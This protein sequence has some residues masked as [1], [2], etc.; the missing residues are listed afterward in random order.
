MTI[1][2]RIKQRRKELGLSQ[3]QLA[4][5]MGYKTPSAIC[6]A[7]TVEDNFTTDRIREFAAALETTE[8]YLMGWPEPRVDFSLNDGEKSMIIEYRKASKASR[9]MI[10]RI[11]ALLNEEHAGHFKL[12]GD[13]K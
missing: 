11:F 3:S 12:G 9:E 1:G 10:D 5:K 13:D 8:N 4:E 6:K 7:E 2:E